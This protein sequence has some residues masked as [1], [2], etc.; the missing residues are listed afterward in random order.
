MIISIRDAEKKLIDGAKVVSML[1]GITSV[2]NSKKTLVLQFTPPTEDSVLN[3]LTGKAIKENEIMSMYAFSDDG[4]DGMAIRAENAD[5]TKEHFDEC[6]TPV[7]EKE[8]MLD[9]LK[10]TKSEKYRE[11]LS[12]EVFENILKGSR[13][14]YDYIYVL[15]PNKDPALVE[16][17]TQYTDEDIILVP[18]GEKVEVDLSNGKTILCVK[19]FE[20]A[21][22]FDY[23]SLK[24]RYGVKK[25]YTVPYN[26]SFRD[27]VTTQTVLDYILINKKI[28]K[29]D[30]NFSLFHSINTLI[31]RYVTN[32]EDEDDEIESQFAS[33][34]VSIPM[35]VD[36]MD[37]LPPDSIQEVTVKRGLF[38]RK[39]KRIMINL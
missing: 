15:I 33:K 23:T 25:L 36:K 6:A 30:D 21:S 39:E 32:E 35:M 4:L 22:K 18:Q 24:K 7:L 13:K 37:E 12:D 34:E 27:A 3:V 1:A 9:V 31:K 8:N 11:V 10:P 28:I 29:E 5:L 2:G 20:A 19:E 26:V 14:V 38:R 16:M 17:V